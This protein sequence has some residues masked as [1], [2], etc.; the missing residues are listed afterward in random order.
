MR[1]MV[2][3][4]GSGRVRVRGRD[5]LHVPLHHLRWFPSPV[6]GGLL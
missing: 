3:G 6:G 5:V 4:H 1:S 2:E